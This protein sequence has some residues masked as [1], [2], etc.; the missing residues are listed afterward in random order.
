MLW[1]ICRWRSGAPTYLSCFG[2]F[3]ST[4]D[5]VYVQDGTSAAPPSGGRT[6]AMAPAEA[7]F[8]DTLREDLERFNDFFIGKEE[9]W[10]AWLSSHRDLCAES[11]V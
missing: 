7:Q 1:M 6:A 10:S 8:V 2:R 9:V 3:F 5:T 11:L 4:H